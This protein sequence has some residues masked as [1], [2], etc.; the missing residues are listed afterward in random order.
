[1]KKDTKPSNI[2]LSLEIYRTENKFDSYMTK[3][4]FCKFISAELTGK[5]NLKENFK[6]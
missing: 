2:F 6:F 3:D 4:A 5:E 1:M